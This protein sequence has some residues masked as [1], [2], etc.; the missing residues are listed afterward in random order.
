MASL[1]I[2]L[3]LSMI[4]CMLI[5]AYLG[6]AICDALRILVMYGGGSG[7]LRAMSF[8]VGWGFFDA[9]PPMA[10]VPMPGESRGSDAV[11]CSGMRASQHPRASRQSIPARPQWH[12]AHSIIKAGFQINMIGYQIK[13]N[14]AETTKRPKS[15]K[16][17]RDFHHF[18]E[19]QKNR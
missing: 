12:W 2:Y 8:P 10:V 3:S 5:G 1:R 14:L 11:G 4:G 13:R 18:S 9:G 19:F 6:A 16:K 7:M 15:Q 17:K